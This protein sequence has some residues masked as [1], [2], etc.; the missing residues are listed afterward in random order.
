MQNGSIEKYRRQYFEF[1]T[2][3]KE[4]YFLIAALLYIVVNL[5]MG[6]LI[7]YTLLSLMKYSLSKFKDY[8][9]ESAQ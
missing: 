4:Y 2:D 6:T 8:I 1:F 7:G 3:G 9:K 5:L